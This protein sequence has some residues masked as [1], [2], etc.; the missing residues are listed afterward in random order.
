MG[1]QK[2][3][4]GSVGWQDNNILNLGFGTS[5]NKNIDHRGKRNCAYEGDH[6]SLLHDSMM[7]VALSIYFLSILLQP[8]RKRSYKKKYK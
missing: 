3:Y 7:P 4:F 2:N 1:S 8:K 5:K 6:S